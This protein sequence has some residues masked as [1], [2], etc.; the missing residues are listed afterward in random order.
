MVT[1]VPGIQV[2][3]PVSAGIINEENNQ[4]V[5]TPTICEILASQTQPRAVN[6]LMTRLPAGISNLEVEGNK[7]L[8]LI[9]GGFN[10]RLTGAGMRLYEMAEHPECVNIIGASDDVQDGMK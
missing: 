6:S 7:E 10:N 4:S 5:G 2:M 9:D 3:T 8:C 1:F